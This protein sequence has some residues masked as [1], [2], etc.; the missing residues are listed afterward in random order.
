MTLK[1]GSNGPLVTAWQHTMVRRFAS[2]AKAANGG[3]LQVDGYYGYDDRDVQREY[4][5]RTNQ[6]V[7]GEVSDADLRAL[8]LATTTAPAQPRHL[9]VVFRGTG[10]IIGQDYVSRVCQGA[11]ELVEEVNP[12]WPATMGGIP[13]GAARDVRAPSMNK[14]VQIAVAD[15]QRI[16]TDALRTNP[17]R[18]VVVGGYSAGA[19]AAAHVRKWLHDHHPDNYLCSFSV[20]DPTRPFGGAYYLGP[21][22]AGQGISSWRYG[23]PQDWRHCWLTHPDDMYGN[24]P[25]GATGDIMDT[26][27]DMV[28]ATQLSDPLGTVRA[29]LP[30]VFE[31]LAE[32]GITLPL[33]GQLG[34]GVVSG[35]PAAF[36]GVLLPALG[37]MLPGLIAAAG[38]NTSALTGPAAAVQAAIIGLRFAAAGTGP[39]IRYEHNEVWPGQTYLG[40]A[41]QHVRDHATRTPALAA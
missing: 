37:S 39:H 9:A 10:G 11:A 8:G 33:I 2:Y 18:K 31:I 40:L 15:A 23:D 1:L 6:P 20:G 16:I 14:A 3:P 28:T 17:R 24:V 36:A 32:A 25:L 22:L 5:R 26:A 29:L 38:G 21:I 41:V 30:K 7:T 35:N 13:V 4:Q 34:V 12:D 27:Y 19:V